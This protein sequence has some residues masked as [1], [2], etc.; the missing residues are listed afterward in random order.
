MS[1]NCVLTLNAR[2]FSI[3]CVNCVLNVEA[4]VAAS[5]RGLFHD[6]EPTSGPSFPAIPAPV[7]SV[8]AVSNLISG[9]GSCPCV[10][11]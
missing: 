5:S 10:R 2:P 6:C 1:T 9:G 8:L 11:C 3:M 7:D 4:V